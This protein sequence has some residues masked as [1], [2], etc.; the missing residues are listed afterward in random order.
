[1]LLLPGG[2]PA[3]LEVCSRSSWYCWQLHV[4]KADATLAGA[5]GGNDIV[6]NTSNLH[7]DAVQD[8]G[9]MPMQTGTVKTCC[10]GTEIA[11]AG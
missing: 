8:S 5:G 2:G 7:S 3:H 4:D 10:S 1:M 9:S 6:T 11:S